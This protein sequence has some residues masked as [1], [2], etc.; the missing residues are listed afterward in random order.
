[1]YNTSQ[2]DL[3]PV[4]DKNAL[5]KSFNVIENII[6]NKNLKDNEKLYIFNVSLENA[7][8]LLK[9]KKDLIENMK[10]IN[11]NIRLKT[12]SSVRENNIKTRDFNLLN[13]IEHRN[14]FNI[15]RENNQK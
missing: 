11:Q 14:S 5:R 12:I 6:N 3:I 1:M 8:Y 15:G 10:K 2:K 13:N 9:E 7:I 4:L